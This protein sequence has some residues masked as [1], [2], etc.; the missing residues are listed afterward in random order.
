[1]LEFVDEYNRIFPKI[2]KTTSQAVRLKKQRP[3]FLIYRRGSI[4]S[5]ALLL[6]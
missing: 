4:D 3:A 1:M 6:S 2:L 5:V